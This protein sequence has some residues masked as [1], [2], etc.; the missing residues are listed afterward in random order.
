MN[1]TLIYEL[2]Y[3][4]ILE[5]LYSCHIKKVGVDFQNCKDGIWN[6]KAL[7][8]VELPRC[9]IYA[10]SGHPRMART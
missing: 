2:E 3:Y 1:Y 6:L 8:Y 7:K 4:K 5:L 10:G 9:V